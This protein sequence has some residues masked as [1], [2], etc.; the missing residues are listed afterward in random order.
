MSLK[1][2]TGISHWVAFDTASE[3]GART[4]LTWRLGL[5]LG[6]M[7]L[8]GQLD[9]IPQ[10]GGESGR[11]EVEIQHPVNPQQT[12]IFLVARVKGEAG[13]FSEMQPKGREDGAA[14]SL[15]GQVS[16]V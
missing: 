11:L 14:A 9:C 13:D 10:N 8:V 16:V 15:V 4:A 7:N 5:Q 6:I 3:A 1:D 12:V 2:P